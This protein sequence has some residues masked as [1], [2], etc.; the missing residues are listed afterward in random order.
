MRPL[1]AETTLP[2]PADVWRLDW[3]GHYNVKVA[4]TEDEE[5]SRF[6]QHFLA[7][8]RRKPAPLYLGLQG[9]G[10]RLHHAVSTRCKAD[11]GVLVR[12]VEPGSPA[13]Q[14]GILEGDIVLTLD[15][16]HVANADELFR[17]LD[18][19]AADVPVT[20]E[21]V[22]RGRRFERLLLPQRRRPQRQL[23]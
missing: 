9:Y 19:L 11:S 6:W 4:C 14:A 17:T 5:M 21:L 12:V 16:R 23:P 15:E 10:I 20:I 18:C 7:D 3:T 13:E 2:L 8:G 1:R 22:R